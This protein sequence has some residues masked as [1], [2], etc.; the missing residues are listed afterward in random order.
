MKILGSRSGALLASA[1]ALSMLATPAMARG[2]WGG[3]GWGHRDRHDDTGAWVVGGIIGIGMIAAIASAA[4]KSKRDREARNPDRDYRDDDY[5][6]DGY[7]NDGYRSGDSRYSNRSDDSSRQTYSGSNRGLDG[8]VDSCV[9]EVE[10]GS[11]RVDTVDSVDR[12]GSGWRV[13][14]RLTGGR[15][16]D[17]AVEANGRIRSATVDGRAVI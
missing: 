10:R 4:S 15:A 14:G 17:C 13:T 5:R 6:N 11:T 8:A 9:G 7:R 1:A 16:F 3:G 2:G 12:D